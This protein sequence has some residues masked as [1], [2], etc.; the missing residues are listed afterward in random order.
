MQVLFIKICRLTLMIKQLLAR[1]S[2]CSDNEFDIKNRFF[3]P[4]NP[5]FDIS[6]DYMHALIREICKMTLIINKP[7]TSAPITVLGFSF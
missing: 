1:R 7:A 5:Y 4:K 3:N 6:Y 2:E